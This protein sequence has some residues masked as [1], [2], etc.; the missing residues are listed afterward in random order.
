MYYFFSSFLERKSIT[1]SVNVKAE[2]RNNISYYF[3][4]FKKHAHD[5]LKHRCLSE[6]TFSV[7]VYC[8]YNDFIM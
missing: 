2:F 8:F 3:S 4:D 7:I 1:H 5:V 6:M